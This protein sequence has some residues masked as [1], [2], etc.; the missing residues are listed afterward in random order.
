M[1]APYSIHCIDYINWNCFVLHFEVYCL[2]QQRSVKIV[3]VIFSMFAKQWPT[4]LLKIVFYERGSVEALTTAIPP[5]IS[6]MWH[7]Y[8]QFRTTAAWT[9]R[10]SR[11]TVI[12]RVLPSNSM[13]PLLAPRTIRRANTSRPP[14]IPTAS[15]LL[16]I[17]VVGQSEQAASNR[18]QPAG[19]DNSNERRLL[20]LSP[21]KNIVKRKHSKRFQTVLFEWLNIEI[22]ISLP[23]KIFGI[24]CRLVH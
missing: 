4:S 20:H 17:I 24:G 2:S 9:S 16:L 7:V 5:H 1:D 14:P 13:I 8:L 22:F 12:L 6:A 18:C 23:P 15:P 3:V 21:P 10:S 19:P 11:T